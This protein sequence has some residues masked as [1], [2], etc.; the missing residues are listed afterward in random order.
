MRSEVGCLTDGA[1]RGPENHTALSCVSVTSFEIG[2]CWVPL[3]HASPILI[4]CPGSFVVGVGC[5]AIFFFLF[6]RSATMILIGMT[7]K[8]RVATGTAH[9]FTR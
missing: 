9:I 8:L 3:C 7:L 1:S 2:K 6:L 4:C 5:Y